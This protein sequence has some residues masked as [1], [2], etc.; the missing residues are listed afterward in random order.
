VPLLCRD[1]QGPGRRLQVL[2]PRP[3]VW[4]RPV[5]R[6]PAGGTAHDGKAALVR[7]ERLAVAAML[8]GIV[9][10]IVAGLLLGIA[11]TLAGIAAVAMGSSKGWG[12]I[13]P[14][15]MDILVVVVILGVPL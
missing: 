4:C 7:R 14:G 9:G 10:L 12:G 2:R 1:R 8:A 6:H 3:P 5:A 15:V 13:V 11:A